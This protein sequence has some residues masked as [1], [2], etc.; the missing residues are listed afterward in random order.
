MSPRPIDSH[1]LRTLRFV[2][3]D[4]TREPRSPEQ[5]RA[6]EMRRDLE[7]AFRRR[8]IREGEY[9]RQAAEINA[10]L[11]DRPGL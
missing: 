5:R 4:G 11:A 8:D 1:L 10:W 2:R 6:E 7:R 3:V 9:R